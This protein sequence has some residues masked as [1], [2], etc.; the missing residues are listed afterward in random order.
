MQTTNGIG[1]FLQKKPQYNFMI[2]AR[3]PIEIAQQIRVIMIREKLKWSEVLT[4][5][6]RAFIDER[7]LK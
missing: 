1:K 3:V 2:Q 5:C 7:K 4:A 6:L